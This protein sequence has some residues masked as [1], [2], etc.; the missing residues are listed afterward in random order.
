MP[1]R[2]Y[3]SFTGKFIQ[4]DPSGFKDGVN[5]YKYACNN[6]LNYVDP[7]GLESGDNESGEETEEDEKLNYFNNNENKEVDAPSDLELLDK[8]F[9]DRKP[10][11]IYSLSM[12]DNRKTLPGRRKSD[13]YI[14][15]DIEPNYCDN[16]LTSDPPPSPPPPP[17]PP[18]KYEDQEN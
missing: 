17:P 10:G 13:S 18:P 3:D 4:H 5:L 14:P 6:P 16:L 7:Y 8:L 2:F 1:Y 12:H 15:R 9:P 11:T